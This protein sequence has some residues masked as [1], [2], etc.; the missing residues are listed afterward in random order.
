MSVMA[1]KAMPTMV[2]VVPKPNSS[3]ING[4]RGV[5]SDVNRMMGEMCQHNREEEVLNKKVGL[6]LPF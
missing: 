6:L 1:N 3:R 2:K 4:K 5:G